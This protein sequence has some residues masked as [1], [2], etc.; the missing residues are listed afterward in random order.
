MAQYRVEGQATAQ[1]AMRERRRAGGAAAAA[2]RD[3]GRREA[4]RLLRHA[5]QEGDEAAMHEALD[6]WHV[7]VPDLFWRG[8]RAGA[9]GY[10]RTRLRRMY[11]A[12]GR[13]QLEMEVQGP[14][15][16]EWQRHGAV[17]LSVLQ[18]LGREQCA[19][20]G[21][22]RCRLVPA[23]EADADSSS[24]S[25]AEAIEQEEQRAAAAAGA[26]RQAAER[27]LAEAAAR[28]GAEEEAETAGSAVRQL[29][30]VPPAKLLADTR[31]GPAAMAVL[32]GAG[33]APRPPP[34]GLSLARAPLRCVPGCQMDAIDS[35]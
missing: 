14:S 7:E 8:R 4:S 30:R 33:E 6:E 12:R 15:A 27:Q 31:M 16:G 35:V 26:R 28:A 22:A 29:R 13:W 20:A 17:V 11:V 18:V 1:R 19:G 2:R 21:E 34:P 32:R 5:W 25:E 3:E 9:V 10:T 23:A 24:D